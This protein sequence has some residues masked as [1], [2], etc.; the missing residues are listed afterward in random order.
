[1]VWGLNMPSNFGMFFPNG[2]HVGWR[3]TLESY[4]YEELSDSERS[5]FNNRLATFRRTVSEKFT[6]N[7]DPLLS[8]EQPREIKTDQRFNKIA[9]L[10]K[11]ENRLL[12]VD[13]E[14]KDTIE[15]F[16]SGAHQFW[17]MKVYS[18]SGRDYGRQFFGMVVRH[19]VDGFSEKH[20]SPDA[21]QIRS[22]FPWI[23][24]ERYGEIA[25]SKTASGGKHL[26]RE[27][28]LYGLDLY[29]S[30]ELQDE[31]VA[32]GLRVPKFHKL[33]GV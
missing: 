13:H 27:Q 7:R 14:L 25:I 10:A 5:N 15:Y 29:F 26:W 31:I 23:Q 18:P 22:G 4:F 20:S 12:Y 2:E 19:F 8:H 28:R 33:R 6:K 11:S 9:S 32:R 3:E 16:D 30:D 1:M 17:E 21:W 24:N